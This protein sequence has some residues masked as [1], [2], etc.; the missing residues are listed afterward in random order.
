MDVLSDVLGVIRIGGAALFHGQFSEP[1]C[2]CTPP[3]QEIAR[4]LIPGAKRAILF[5]IIA[6]GDCWAE[7]PGSP[8]L[9]LTAGDV[10]VLPFGDA[11]ALADTPGREPVPIAG[12]LP[13]RPWPRLPV[14]EYGGTG[15]LTRILCGFLHAD[16]VPLH[17][18]LSGLPSIMRVSE[19][20]A[21][22]EPRLAGIVRYILDEAR[23]PHPGST[24][25]LTRMIEVLFIEILRRQMSDN[26]EEQIKP[27][28]AMTDP[29]IRRSLEL[30]HA[31]PNKAWTLG[32]LAQAA[33]TS[34]SVLAERFK[35]HLGCPPMHY[36][37]RW[38]LQLAANR[39]CRTGVCTAAV[40]EEAGYVSEAAFSRAFK[41]YIGE[42]PAT[43]RRRQLL[44]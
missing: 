3:A 40:A 42:P 19:R 16:D 41:R 23:S 1:W 2:V 14:V 21:E 27:M 22:Q 34:R 44:N 6:E 4:R 10:V 9:R 36:L 39:L 26:S 20:A 7:K 33:G 11:H 28:A 13:P 43:W 30:L 38:R 5:H 24:C 8:P 37:M 31:V 18:L 25:L 29:L 32:D 12:L 17:P 15:Q 35:H